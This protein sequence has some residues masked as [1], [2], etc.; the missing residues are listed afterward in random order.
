MM[1]DSSTS[2]RKVC[3]IHEMIAG[4][5]ALIASGRLIRAMR[6]NTYAHAIVPTLRVITSA[7]FALNPSTSLSAFLISRGAKRAA[8]AKRSRLFTG[9][10]I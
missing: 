6:P 9:A 3:A 2:C 1:I 8:W 5:P 7:T 10:F 4:L